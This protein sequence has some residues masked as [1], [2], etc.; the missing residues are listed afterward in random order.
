MELT[1][2]KLTDVLVSTENNLSDVRSELESQLRQSEHGLA[3]TLGGG[4][5]NDRLHVLGT[6]RTAVLAAMMELY[7]ERP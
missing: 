1:M 4:S 3:G 6:L 2:E 5:L 7:S